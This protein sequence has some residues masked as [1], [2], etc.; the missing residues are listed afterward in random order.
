MIRAAASPAVIR[1]YNMQRLLVYHN[2][3]KDAKIFFFISTSEGV[4]RS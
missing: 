3:N 4:E 1:I 2:I